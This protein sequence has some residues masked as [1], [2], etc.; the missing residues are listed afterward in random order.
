MDE[1]VLD[2]SSNASRDTL[3]YAVY[4]EKHA[5]RES[6]KSDLSW[7]PVIDKN[8]SD[9]KDKYKA[10]KGICI[11][12]GYMT[13]TEVKCTAVFKCD[14]YASVDDVLERGYVW[15]DAVVVGVVNKWLRSE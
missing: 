13:G 9:Q 7:W 14:D 6:E 3:Y 11:W 12:N 4:S 5:R 10:K 15:D 8:C 1:I 2:M